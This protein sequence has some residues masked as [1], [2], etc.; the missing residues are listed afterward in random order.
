[1]Q[2]LIVSRNDWANV[3]YDLQ[4][5]ARAAGVEALAVKLRA[6][7]LQYPRQAKTITKTLMSQ[8]ARG[9]ES[10]LFC[11]SMCPDLPVEG[12]QISVFHGG[13]EYRRAYKRINKRFNKIADVAFIQTAELMRL[14][15]KNPVWLIPGI[16]PANIPEPLPPHRI[17][18]FAHYPRGLKKGS[19]KIDTAAAQALRGS[20]KAVYV[21]NRE[22]VPWKK[23]LERMSQCDIYIE[24]LNTCG[25]WGR[26]A[27]EAAMMGKVV[28][29]NFK[30]GDA[31]YPEHFGEHPLLVAN[32]AKEVSHQ[33]TRCLSWTDAE[34]RERQDATR[35]W[36]LSTHS[37]EAT[38][39][40]ISD[41]LRLSGN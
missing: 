28:I 38:G 37:L 22:T 13:A 18:T 8:Y 4:E 39:R 29:T 19:T 1:M 30:R 7:G 21:T 5:A 6:H 9:S 14:G 26:T 24:C 33:I 20:K 27:L 16:E 25:E 34:L 3:S 15:A 17:R 41:A 10:I 35:E 36:A 23:N 11:H 2:L 40:R 31:I 12:R 32:N